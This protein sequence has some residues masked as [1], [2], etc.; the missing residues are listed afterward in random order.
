NAAPASYRHNSFVLFDEVTHILVVGEMSATE[1]EESIGNSVLPDPMSRRSCEIMALQY[2]PI[3]ARRIAQH[4]RR[5]AAEGHPEA[6]GT[7]HLTQEVDVHFGNPNP[8][9]LAVPHKSFTVDA[10]IEHQ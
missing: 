2:L 4:G 6:E 9:S 8:E 3:Q 1:M 7:I 10:W 5:N